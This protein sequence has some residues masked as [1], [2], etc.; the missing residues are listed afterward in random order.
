M[1]EESQREKKMKTNEQLI[2]QIKASA[3]CLGDSMSLQRADILLSQAKEQGINAYVVVYNHSN[4]PVKIYSLLHEID[5]L[6][7]AV[8]EMPKD[9]WIALLKQNEPGE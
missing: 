9:E 5:D 2:E 4:E 8:V 1:T 6:Y 7:K 3:V